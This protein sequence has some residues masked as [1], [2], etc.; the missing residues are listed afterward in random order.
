MKTKPE[1][2]IVLVSTTSDFYRMNGTLCLATVNL[3]GSISPSLARSTP[4]HS[5]C[6]DDNPHPRALSAQRLHLFNLTS[7]PSYTRNNSAA[8]SSILKLYVSVSYV[9]REPQCIVRVE[10]KVVNGTVEAVSNRVRFDIDP[11]QG[12]SST[13]NHIFPRGSRSVAGSRNTPWTRSTPST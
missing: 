12:D 11:N 13:T 4:E 3:L 1:N 5:L 7:V 10:D 6:A 9:W 2:K 8:T